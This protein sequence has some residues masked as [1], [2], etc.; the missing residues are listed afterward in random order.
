MAVPRQRLAI[1]PQRIDDLLA[2]LVAEDHVHADFRRCDDR[3]GS[4][5]EALQILPV[6]YARGGQ[7]LSDGLRPEQLAINGLGHGT[8]RGHQVPFELGTSVPVFPREQ[9]RDAQDPRQEADQNQ[10][11]EQRADAPA[12]SKAE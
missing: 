11:Q 2:A 8:C 4:S 9:D 10:P 5:V 1:V 6:P 3:S 12:A 7:Y